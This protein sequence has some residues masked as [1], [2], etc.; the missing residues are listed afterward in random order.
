[1]PNRAFVYVYFNSDMLAAFGVHKGAETKI[2]I[3]LENGALIIRR[4]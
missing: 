1:V 2:S 3:N 4:A